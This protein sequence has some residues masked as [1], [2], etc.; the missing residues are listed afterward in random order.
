MNKRAHT[1]WLLA[2]ALALFFGIALQLTAQ[3]ANLT[4]TESAPAAVPPMLQ[5]FNTAWIDKAVDPCTDF[6]RFACGNWLKANPLPADQERIM[7]FG[8]MN[9]RNFY[10][11]YKQLHQAAVSPSTPLERQYGAFFAACMDADQAN[12]LGSKPLQPTLQAI[13]ALTDKAQLAAFLSDKR[14]LGEVF[15]TFTV[16]QDDKDAQQQI[17]TLQQGGLTLPGPGDYLQAGAP[18]DKIRTQYRIYLETIFQLLGDRPAEASAE[19]GNVLTIETALAR[20]SMSRADMRDPDK[21]YHPTSLAQLGELAPGFRWPTYFASLQAPPFTTINVRQPDYLRTMSQVIAAEPLPALKSYLRIHAV[22][23][24]A[25]YLSTRFEQASFLF[26]NQTLRGQAVEQARWKRCTVLTNKL[27]PDAV[28]QAWVRQNFSPQSKAAVE[29]IIANV[30]DAF[31]TEIDHLSW[32]SPEAKQEADRKLLTMREKIGYPAHWRSYS[33]LQITRND[34]VSDLHNAELFNDEEEQSHIGQPVDESRFYWTAPE[35]DGNYNE[36]FNDIEFPAGVLQPPK[37]SPSG[38]PAVNYGGIGTF[39]GHEITHGFDDVGSRYDE[40]GNLHSWFSAA[41]QAS[42]NRMTS[43]EVSEYNHF[44]AA[45]GLKL[46]G[47]LSLGEDTADNGGLRI[48]YDALQSVLA[49]QAPSDRSRKID[50]LTPD[51]R[52][53]LSFAQNWCELRTD[54]YQR[55]RGETDPHPPGEFR[56]N[57]SVQNLEPFG[58]AFDCHPGQPMMPTTACHVW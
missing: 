15:F 17:P 12:A 6:Y 1:R 33:H 5:A 2:L 57:G 21:T 3:T 14:Y 53:F 22:T 49:H 11:L 8:Q 25:P 54:A 34:F 28:G 45:P 50:G 58:Q 37:Y 39:V 7:V 30:R 16:E 20:G 47:K 41:D 40:R 9:D 10:L 52:F 43:C 38:D 31:R 42:F 19:A 24:V 23:P 4:A 55:V 44:E 27:L 29:E 32:M 36:H 18:Q 51:Q 13:D 48:A 26:F 56:V 46:D 35:A